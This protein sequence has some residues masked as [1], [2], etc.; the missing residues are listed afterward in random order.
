MRNHNQPQSTTNPSIMCIIGIGTGEERGVQGG[1]RKP[2]VEF[3]ANDSKAQQTGTP[4]S[5]SK[6]EY[7]RRVSKQSRA[8]KKLERR[9]RK[10]AKREAKDAAVEEQRAA[11]EAEEPGCFFCP[12]I[13]CTHTLFFSTRHARDRHVRNR[14]C[15]LNCKLSTTER[16]AVV[17]AGA[18]GEEGTFLLSGQSVGLDAVAKRSASSG[19]TPAAV[20]RG[21]AE[22][23]HR[24]D[25]DKVSSKQKAEVRKLWVKGNQSK[26]ERLTS[27]SAHAQLVKTAKRAAAA[28][29]LPLGGCCSL[30]IDSEGRCVPGNATVEYRR[31][32]SP[33]AFHLPSSSLLTPT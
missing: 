32:H 4:I 16:A 1:L 31:G 30:L 21:M 29:A 13:N 15:K 20:Q 10:R 23:V 5:I 14:E 3:E 8:D 12:N 33:V 24:P 2:Q 9:A 6:G 11:V 27:K 28:R 7:E 18:I 17:A 26:A 25:K 22:R 19:F